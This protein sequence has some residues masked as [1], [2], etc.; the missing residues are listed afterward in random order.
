MVLLWMGIIHLHY[1][2]ITLILETFKVKKLFNKD[3]IVISLDNI[4]KVVNDTLNDQIKNLRNEVHKNHKELN[5][6][7]LNLQVN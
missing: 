7:I 4:N 2:I 6:L 3:K 1:N 5:D